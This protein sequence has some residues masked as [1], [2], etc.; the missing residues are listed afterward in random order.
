VVDL[1]RGR[2]WDLVGHR[3]WYFTLS[4]IVLVIGMY[5]WITRGLNYGIDFTGGGLITYEL[6]KPVPIARQVE[7]LA[8][9][10]SEVARLGYDAE[11]NIAR[12]ALGGKDQLLARTKIDP[13]MREQEKADLVSTQAERIEEALE[14]HY[15]GIKVIGQDMVGGVV[16]KELIQNA[17]TAVV[18][19]MLLV[20]VWIIIRYD[21]QY[22]TCAIVALAHDC[23]ILTGI[24]A[25]LHREV[26]APFVAALLTVVG[27]SV[28]DTIV[29]FDRIRENVKLRKGR[30]FGET[31]NTSLL[32]TMARSVNT[33]LPV[34]LAIVAL[35]LLGGPTIHDFCLAMLIG[36]LCGTY[37]SI[38]NAAQFVV[39]WKEWGKRPAPRAAEGRVGR[40]QTPATAAAAATNATEPRSPVASGPTSSRAE[41]VASAAAGASVSTAA[42]RKLKAKKRKRRY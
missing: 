23:L 15:P 11:V 30:T 4:G 37:S 35:F 21:Y 1:F 24:F 14:R 31:V 7:T 19:G 2:K 12:P 39:V 32:E 27:Y 28:H 3:L 17:I 8:T 26:N 33:G 38:F 18:L 20:V 6:P 42:K 9:V 25:L 36:L 29:I 41:E 34:L 13:E 16:S 40:L 10:R 22:A 5:F